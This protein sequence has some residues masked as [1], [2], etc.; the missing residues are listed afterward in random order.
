MRCLRPL[1]QQLHQAA[2]QLVNFLSPIGDVHG[3][4]YS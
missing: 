3:H 2:I 4:S 1:I